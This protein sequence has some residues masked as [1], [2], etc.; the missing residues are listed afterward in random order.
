[1]TRWWIG[2][3]AAVIVAAMVW[4]ARL[5]LDPENLPIR[6]V[7]VTG[8]FHYLSRGRLE[9]VVSTHTGDGFFRVDLELLRRSVL[10]MPWVEDVSVRRRW[11]G[12]L[13]LEVRERQAVARWVSGGFLD[14][15]GELFR[16]EAGSGPR[17][18]PLLE[19]PE[20]SQALVLQGL[21]RI[22]DWLHPAGLSVTRA[23]LNRRHAW[24]LQLDSGATLVLG[25]EPRRKQVMRF[26]KAL[27]GLMADERLGMERVDLRYPNGFAIL[28][29]QPRGTERE[30]LSNEQE[31]R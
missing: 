30:R 14:A 20:G 10:E 11:P 8:A 18:L 15:R 3:L 26:V 25:Q 28:W 13:L 1:M 19:G 31:D 17:G 22:Q 5:A 6:E 2:G 7:V 9:R 4:G 12:S 23:T 16:P 21:N 27:P 24:R 29:K